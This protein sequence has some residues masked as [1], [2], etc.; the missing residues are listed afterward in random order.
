MANML[1]CSINWCKIVILEGVTMQLV[2]SALLSALVCLAPMC[3]QE[4]I[5]FAFFSLEYV[6]ENSAQAKRIFA[7]SE[8]L[9]KK[10]GDE[11]QA[12][13]SDLQRLEQQLN[14]SSLSEEGR[15]RIARDLEDGKTL[16]KRMQEDAQSQF[17]RASQTALGQ[18]N[19]EIAPIV[20]A[21]AKEQKLNCV[22][23]FNTNLIAWADESWVWQFSQEVAKRYDVAYP[24]GG[25]AS[26]PAAAATS[27]TAVKK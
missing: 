25:G 26:R 24:A 20:E 7:D 11:I 16:L 19:R 2:K 17:N 8:V 1:P 27:P 9:G 13:A 15:S 3:A 22:M 10:L 18:F 14:S 4:P 21:L 12:K 23:N 6:V 5:R